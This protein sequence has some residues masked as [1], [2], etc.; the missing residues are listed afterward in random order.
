MIDPRIKLTKMDIDFSQWDFINIALTKSRQ[1]CQGEWC[2]LTE[3]DMIIHEIEKER[4]PAALNRAEAKG[5]EAIKVREFSCI[6][7]L[8]D[9]DRFYG[10]GFRQSITRNEPWLYHKTSDYM[11]RIIDS[12]IWDGKCIKDYGFDDFS[13]YDERS[14]A[15]FY[16]DKADFVELDYLKDL[17]FALA[18]YT[19]LWHYGFFNP[20]RKNAQ[21]RQI[22]QWQDRVY[23]RSNTFD[24]EKQIQLLKETLVINPEETKNSIEYFRS[25]GFTKCY[26][27][28]PKIVQKWVDSM[29]VD[30]I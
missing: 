16:S 23:G 12:K 28:H 11:I 30:A 18:N 6:Q 21:G 2:F 17:D 9:L 1:S 22:S 15:K 26:I 4:I 10:G 24:I 5:H 3:M 7:N 25:N 27:K 19:Y 29:G 13:Y 14:G 8:V 20:G